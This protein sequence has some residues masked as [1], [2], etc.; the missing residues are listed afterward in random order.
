MKLRVRVPFETDLN[1]VRKLLKQ[2]GRE[3][4]EIE[5]IKDNFLQPFKA[6]G[7]VDVDDYGF[8]ISTKFMAK[9]GTQFTIRRYAF[10]AMQD[11]FEAN[12]IPFARPRVRVVVDD[13]S[14]GSAASIEQAAVTG[15]AASVVSKAKAE[16]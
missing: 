12:G 4:M 5:A 8:V 14:E 6:Q 16:K 1:M 13:E 9:P 3:M 11:A 2:V 15:V 10:Q 7:A